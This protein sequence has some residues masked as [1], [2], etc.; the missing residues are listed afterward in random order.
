VVFLHG[1]YSFSRITSYLLVL[2]VSLNLKIL[3]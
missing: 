2:G 1:H 3:R